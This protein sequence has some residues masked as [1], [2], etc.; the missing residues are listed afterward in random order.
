[1]EWLALTA[2]STGSVTLST[3]NNAEGIISETAIDFGIATAGKKYVTTA[4]WSVA[5]AATMVPI[6]DFKKV[7]AAGRAAGLKF[8]YAFMNLTLYD[9]ITGSTEYLNAAKAFVGLTT[10]DILG[11]QGVAFT[12]RILA[13]MSLP[14]IVI[15]DTYVNLESAAGVITSV[16]PWSDTHI[17]FSPTIQL[18]NFHA[19]PIAEELEKPL[20]VLQSKRGPVLLSVRKEFNPSAVLTKGEANVFPSWTN[21]DE[22]YSLYTGSTSAWA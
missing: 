13:A 10:T 15:V 1:M 18:G 7:V 5:N 8:N 19:G 17:L 2:I 6:T 14:Q 9:I 4:T 21:V 12:N 22:C 3:T 20:D 11:V 16:N